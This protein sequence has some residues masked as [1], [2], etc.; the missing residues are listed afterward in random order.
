MN[1]RFN[2]ESATFSRFPAMVVQAALDKDGD[3]MLSTEEIDA[4][5]ESLE[6]LD[7]NGDGQITAADLQPQSAESSAQQVPTQ[8]T[9]SLPPEPNPDLE[10]VR[11]R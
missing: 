3:G 7:H 6:A 1:Q 2:M 8:R 4:A 9:Q 10:P 11:P 5:V